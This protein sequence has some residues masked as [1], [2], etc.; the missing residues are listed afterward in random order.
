MFKTVFTI[1]FAI[2]IHQTPFSLAR[3]QPSTMLGG[4]VLI[5]AYSFSA[6]HFLV[7]VLYWLWNRITA[8]SFSYL[9]SSGKVTIYISH[10]IFSNRLVWLLVS[11]MEDFRGKLCH[12]LFLISC[13]HIA[14]KFHNRRPLSEQ[15][16]WSFLT[17][18]KMAT[19][20]DFFGQLLLQLSNKGTDWLL[21]V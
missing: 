5:F 2:K 19:V 8:P 11:R 14:C 17:H 9:V 21:F 12:S 20:Q 1:L 15:F 7:F 3:S 13:S 4:N 16:L 18:F 6:I 10:E